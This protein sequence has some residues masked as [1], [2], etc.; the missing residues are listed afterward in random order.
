[1]FD[2]DQPRL[3]IMHG[4]LHGGLNVRVGSVLGHERPDLL[5]LRDLRKWLLPDDCVLGHN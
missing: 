4:R 2:H 3:L 5:A 1:M